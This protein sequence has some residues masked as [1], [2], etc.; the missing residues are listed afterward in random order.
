MGLENRDPVAMQAAELPR[1]LATRPELPLQFLGAQVTVQRHAAFARRA[2]GSR[3]L[4]GI[5]SVG[6]DSQRTWRPGRRVARRH[7]DQPRRAGSCR[8]VLSLSRYDY[9]FA[10]RALIWQVLFLSFESHAAYPKTIVAA[11]FSLPAREAAAASTVRCVPLDEIYF[12]NDHYA[13]FCREFLRM[14]NAEVSESYGGVVVDLDYRP[15]GSSTGHGM[16]EE[17]IL[18][19]VEEQLRSPGR[20]AVLVHGA[21]GCGKTTT[22]KQLIAPFVKI[23]CGA[24]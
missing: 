13:Q 14:W 21:F 7:K 20:M 12:V 4:E 6:G 23:I 16:P 22:A 10:R 8:C 5:T 17:S 18:S 2:S 15:C 1:V 11:R 24:I 9:E 19:F 3:G